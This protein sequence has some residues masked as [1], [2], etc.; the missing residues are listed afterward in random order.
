MVRADV[1]PALMAAIDTEFG[2]NPKRDAAAGY[3]PTRTS[4]VEVKTKAAAKGGFGG[5]LAFGEGR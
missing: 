2:K 1:K 3:A 4:R 5:R